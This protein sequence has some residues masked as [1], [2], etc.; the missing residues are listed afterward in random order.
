LNGRKRDKKAQAAPQQGTGAQQQVKKKVLMACRIDMAAFTVA[1][2]ARLL[3]AHSRTVLGQEV[4]GRLVVD[5]F[6]GNRRQI[7]KN[8][9]C[10]RQG[11]A[12]VFSPFPVFTKT[13]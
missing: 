4:E 8:Q 9:V 7:V 5:K 2:N 13:G 10:H 1:G 3:K 6:C 11:F 12:K